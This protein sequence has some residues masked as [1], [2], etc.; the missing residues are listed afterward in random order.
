MKTSPTKWVIRLNTEQVKGPYSTEAVVKMITEGIFSGT[1]EIC[2][3]PEG[4]WQVL[5]KQPEF[6]EALLESLENP[7][8]VDQKKA[9]KMEAETVVRVP[10]KKKHYGFRQKS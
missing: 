10:A 4:D 5:T 2:G 6:Y 9:Q 3:Y 1:E 8:E 7:A